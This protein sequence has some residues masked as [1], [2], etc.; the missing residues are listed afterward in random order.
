MSL[1]LGEY[2]ERM[3]D[4]Y[5]LGDL[6]RMKGLQLGFPPLMAS[7]A[8][9]EFL[10]GLI[11]ADPFARLGE[12]YFINYWTTH[13]YPTH[14]SAADEAAAIYKLVRNGIAHCFVP[15]GL[16]GVGEMHGNHLKRE[17]SSDWLIVD[18]VELA[19]DFKKSYH[20]SF[21]PLLAD[22]G[23]VVW[24]TSQL[25]R[26]HDQYNKEFTNLNVKNLFPVATNVVASTAEPQVTTKAPVSSSQGPTGP[27]SA[28]NSTT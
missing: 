8:G 6:D 24:L 19:A 12:R 7:F 2:L 9:I 28:S 27:I 23:K 13:L 21:K 18:P 25:D 26:M 17:P 11:D 5:L 20:E 22:A 10:G 16:V 15:K 1:D 3:I 14:T 4:G